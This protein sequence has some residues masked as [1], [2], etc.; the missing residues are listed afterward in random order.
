MERLGIKIAL[1]VIALASGIYWAQPPHLTGGPVLATCG[2]LWALVVL[3]SFRWEKAEDWSYR[4][5][6]FFG[7]TMA[8]VEGVSGMLALQNRPGLFLMACA[9][10]TAF[11]LAV[12]G[13]YQKVSAR[14]PRRSFD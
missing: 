3:T 13:R 4:L 7:V 12:V 1:L 14:R 5:S 10:G 9:H 2:A 8:T 6:S 11:L